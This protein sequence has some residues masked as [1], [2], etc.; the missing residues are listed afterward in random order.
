MIEEEEKQ[1]QVVEE[2][3]D[4]LGGCR[5]LFSGCIYAIVVMMIFITILTGWR[6]V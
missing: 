3:D 1:E 2:L 6:F 4:P 5:S